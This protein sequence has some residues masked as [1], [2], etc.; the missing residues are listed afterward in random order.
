M[1][2]FLETATGATG[3]EIEEIVADEHGEII[4]FHIRVRVP[5]EATAYVTLIRRIIDIEKPA[6]VTYELALPETE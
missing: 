1:R 5:E 6:Y 4:P 3:F 2:L